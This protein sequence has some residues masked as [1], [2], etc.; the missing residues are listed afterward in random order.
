MN[1]KF[2]KDKHSFGIS[3]EFEF[4]ASM[5]VNYQP[6]LDNVNDTNKYSIIDFKIPTT[7]ICIELK[8]RTCKSTTY[9][10]TFFR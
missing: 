6:Q 3:K 2:I 1:A 4:I 5:D 9:A 7:K 10:T 8:R